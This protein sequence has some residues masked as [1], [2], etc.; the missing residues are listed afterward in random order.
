VIRG[1]PRLST[2]DEVAALHKRL[3]EVK[4]AL[5]GP[6][7]VPSLNDLADKMEL[8]EPADIAGFV[9]AVDQG[10]PLGNHGTVLPIA[11]SILAY[12]VSLQASPAIQTTQTGTT[13]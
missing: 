7:D 8:F 9:A 2:K 1:Q 6:D 3:D 5:E 13:P 11:D 4:V 10:A 12:L